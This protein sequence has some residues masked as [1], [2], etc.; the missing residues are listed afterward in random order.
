MI[1][2]DIRKVLLAGDKIGG[3]NCHKTALFLA[4]RYSQEQLFSPDNDNPETA[5]HADIEA[6]SIIYTDPTVF[7]AS[8]G[9]KRF[10]YRVSFFKLRGDKY[11]AY[12]SM[13]VLGV[14]NKGNV[15]GFEKAGP[16]A[17]NPF[18][19]INVAKEITDYLLN[20]YIAGLEKQSDVQQFAR[21]Q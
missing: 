17:D 21:L 11:F 10:P 1:S 9:E 5:G 20:G 16:Y 7:P 19:Y 6:N 14:T 15:V 18:R 12:H 13:M 4:G 8:L 3:A 2:D